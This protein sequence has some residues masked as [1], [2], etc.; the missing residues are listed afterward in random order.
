VEENIESNPTQQSPASTLFSFAPSIK[1]SRRSVSTFED[2]FSNYYSQ[3]Y[4]Q[5]YD[6]VSFWHKHKKVI[7]K[8]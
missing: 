5:S 2:E 6:G 3:V 8:F 7:F 4:E 1:K